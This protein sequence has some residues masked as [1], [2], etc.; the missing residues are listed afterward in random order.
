MAPDL[1]PGV[2]VSEHIAPT[3]SSAAWES[4]SSGAALDDRNL[5]VHSRSYP[6]RVAASILAQVASAVAFE[7]ARGIVPRDLK[8]ENIFLSSRIGTLHYAAPEQILNA[9]EVDHRVDVWSLGVILL[10]R[11]PEERV[12]DVGRMETGLGRS[13]VASS[14]RS[15]IA[16]RGVP[17]GAFRRRGVVEGRTGWKR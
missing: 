1:A 17:S 15:A 14:V 6:V 12:S 11:A 8:P 3:V 9:A 10:S 13:D 4:A 5:P 7:H 16:G 2:V